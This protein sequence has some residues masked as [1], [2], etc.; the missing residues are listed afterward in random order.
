MRFNDIVYPRYGSMREY[1]KDKFISEGKEKLENIL[2]IYAVAK[3][4][5]YGKIKPTTT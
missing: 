2:E 3:G 4:V 1:F 5:L